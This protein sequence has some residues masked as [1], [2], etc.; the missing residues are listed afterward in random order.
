MGRKREL[1]ASDAAADDKFG[2]S[3]ATSGNYAIVGMQ[4]EMI[5]TK[6]VLIFLKE[7]VME[8]GHK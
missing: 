4:M 1:V 3:V 2:K 5:R 6:A 8:R 7:I